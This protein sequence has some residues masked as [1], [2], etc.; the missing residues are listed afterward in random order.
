MVGYRCQITQITSGA[1]NGRLRVSDAFGCPAVRVDS[2]QGLIF[3]GD[4]NPSVMQLAVEMNGNLDLHL[5]KGQQ[6]PPHAFSGSDANSSEIFFSL[7]PGSSMVVVSMPKV[8]VLARAAEVYG[9]P[10]LERLNNQNICKV[11]PADFD[12][13]AQKLVQGMRPDTASQSGAADVD[14]TVLTFLDALDQ[15]DPQQPPCET[16]RNVDLIREFVELAHDAGCDRPLTVS[17][18][19]QELFT[20]KTVLSVAIRQ[21]TG[22]SPLVFLRNVRLEQVRKALL[23]GDQTTSVID[24]AHRYGFPSRGHFSRYY[25]DLFA[26]LPRETLMKR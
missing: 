7:T 22:L 25:R 12:R 1:L 9:E 10:A 5:V 13:M 11:R 24:V 8:R 19:T 17:D 21:A 2:D 4:R 16:V 3:K 26:E 14:D 20:S 6:L 18:L 23:S 15:S